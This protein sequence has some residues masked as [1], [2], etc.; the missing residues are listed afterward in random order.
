MDPTKQT[1]LSRLN[2]VKVE[3]SLSSSDIPK[4]V[5]RE[6]TPL[7]P[8]RKITPSDTFM[9]DTVTLTPARRRHN[10]LGTP[11][12]RLHSPSWTNHAAPETPAHNSSLALTPAMR[13]VEPTTEWKKLILSSATI[14][15]AASSATPGHGPSPQNLAPWSQQL[16]DSGF[17]Q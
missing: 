11:A 8:K 9:K 15:P 7:L 3:A 1:N 2:R 12:M 5:I 14:S 13:R 17:S 10:S 4:I 16:L 6:S